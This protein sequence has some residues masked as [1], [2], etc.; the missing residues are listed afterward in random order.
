MNRLL[1]LLLLIVVQVAQADSPRHQVTA[2][3]PR[4]AGGA[5]TQVE[6][7]TGSVSSA[8][9]T[10]IGY[11]RYGQGPAIVVIHGTHTI[12]Q[13]W[14]AFAKELGRNYT[15]YLFDRRGRGES[16]DTKPYTLDSEIDDLAAMMQ[17][18]GPDSAILGHSFG[19]GVAIAYA[20]RDEFKGRLI[21]Y[22][23][24]HSV[25]G[26]VDRGH[27]PKLQKLMDGKEYSEAAEFFLENI[28]Q[29]PE[30]E[31]AK[32][33]ASPLWPSIV[34][35]NKLAPREMGFLRTLDWTP[36]RLSKLQCRSWLLLGSETKAPPGEISPTAALVDRLPAPTRYPLMGQGHTAY[37][38][39]P[40]LLADVVKRCLTDK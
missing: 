15:V 30:D 2:S 34:E 31:V 1:L 14:S 22:E 18:A 36:E 19:G 28:S 29:M 4:G 12:A 33:K 6:I 20:L 7:T 25:N 27:L 24:G 35:L 13:E 23:A 16:P 17:L 11:S 9:G 8:D 40:S 38:G 3:D 21:T 32:F 5:S 26:P 10:R 39:N 37:V